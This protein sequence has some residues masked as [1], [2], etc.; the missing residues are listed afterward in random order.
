MKSKLLLFFLC[1]SPLLIHAQSYWIN[2]IHYDN[3]G[4]DMGEFVEI[5]GTAGTDM[6]GWS[7][8]LYNGNGGVEYST[9]NLSG[10]I[11]NLENGF[12]VLSFLTPG[13]QNGSPDGLA[14]VD[15]LGDIAVSG[16][17]PQFLSYEGTINAMNGP[18]NGMSSTDIGVDES[19]STPVGYSLQLMDIENISDNQEEAATR[20]ETYG[21]FVWNDPAIA[22]PGGQNSGQAFGNLGLPVTWLSID[23]QVVNKKAIQINWQTATEQNNDHFQVILS[24]DGKEFELVGTLEGQ[25]ESHVVQSYNMEIPVMVSGEYYIMVKQVDFDGQFTYSKTVTV[26]VEIP[27]EYLIRQNA[28]IDFIQLET[29]EASNLTYEIINM[30]QQLITRKNISNEIE[31][32]NIEYLQAGVY[33][34][35]VYSEGQLHFNS[36]FTKL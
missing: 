25:G 23:A 17:I 31:D 22:S 9:I 6:T 14:L 27:R 35:R 20:G 18:A 33:V 13:I 3:S 32:I 30:N 26:K 15:P 16:T 7:L 36:R 2:E 12:G 34:L 21:D 5:A 19:S 11:P 28:A 29:P 24:R 1:V 4:S 8:V 10:T